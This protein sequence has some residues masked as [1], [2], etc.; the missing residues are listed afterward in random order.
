MTEQLRLRNDVEWRQV[1]GQIVAMDIRTAH[2]VA[3][4]ATATP[5][6][7]AL[8]R[9]TTIDELTTTL[10]DAFGIDQRTARRDVDAFIEALR[11]RQL[12]GN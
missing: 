6:W 8:I 3:M 2:C 10:T 11:A 9:G 7:D 5:L 4:N 12:L 1:D